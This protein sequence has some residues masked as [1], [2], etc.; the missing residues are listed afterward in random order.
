LTREVAAQL[1][2]ADDIGAPGFDVLPTAS[3]ALVIVTGPAGSGKS[4]LLERIHQR[5]IAHAGQ[6]ALT[7]APIF[8]KASDVVGSLRDYAEHHIDDLGDLHLTGV[9]L[10]VDG[11]DELAEAQATKIEE[12]AAAFVR[13]YPH[14]R[15]V[16]SSRHNPPAHLIKYTAT[17]RP[18]TN[19]DLQALA[20]RL[21]GTPIEAWRLLYGLPDSM[22]EAVAR[23]LFAIA[24]ILRSEPTMSVAQLM[25]YLIRRCLERAERA[26]IA[27]EL[28][29]NLAVRVLDSDLGLVPTNDI[30]EADQQTLLQTR[31]VYERGNHFGFTLRLIAEYAAAAFLARGPIDQAVLRIS[32][33]EFADRW[34]T[35]L[36]IYLARLDDTQARMLVDR[37]ATEDPGFAY[38]FARADGKEASPPW[39][40]RALGEAMRDSMRAYGA[41]LDRLMPRRADGGMLNTLSALR[42]GWLYTGWRDEPHAQEVTTDP[43]DSMFVPLWLFQ[44]GARFERLRLEA[45]L[46]AQHVFKWIID[47]HIE[48]RGFAIQYGPLFDEELWAVGTAL[49]RRGEFNQEPIPLAELAGRSAQLSGRVRLLTHY[50]RPIFDADALRLR[51]RELLEAGQESIGPPL[52]MRD[53]DDR[54]KVWSGYSPAAIV[55][56]RA[57]VLYHA[58]RV[59]Q[60]IVDQWLGRIALRLSR[61]LLM[62]ALIHEHIQFIQEG[63]PVSSAY[64]EPL[65][66]GGRNEVDVALG[67]P[68]EM[69]SIFEAA[70]HA[71]DTRRPQYN[72]RLGV[73]L[74]NGIMSIWGLRPI[75][76]TAY[77]WL[78]QD[79]HAIGWSKHF[80]LPDNRA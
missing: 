30:P 13:A 38:K 63:E 58:M 37:I 8:A 27:S 11:L 79:L 17:I 64:W 62:P 5:N 73:G 32:N 50:T 42:D 23:P 15:L 44:R 48:N 72:G 9:A 6:S 51:I 25:D 12:D 61:R 49:L 7:P 1:E 40:A 59:Y 34:Q 52:G 29:Q 2:S 60:E 54:G 21:R 43:P 67:E 76:D 3:Q 16:L 33:P 41:A 68:Y 36:S 57:E 18:L 77:R 22:Q 80:S 47:G 10:V 4:L 46:T 31:L 65:P 28:L 26:H 39:E 56:R 66:E 35:V 24:F 78:A 14:S 71:L 74:T 19:V 70:R 69:R 20:E 75:R 53:T 45:N 55:R